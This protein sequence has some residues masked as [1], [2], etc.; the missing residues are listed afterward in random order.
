MA[1]DSRTPRLSNFSEYRLSSS[2]DAADTT[3]F[4]ASVDGLP[5][6]LSPLDY[7]PMVLRDAI[8]GREVIHVTAVDTVNKTVTALR[9]R[10]GTTAVNWGTSAYFYATMTSQA[11]LD[12]LVN[13]WRRPLLAD[14]TVAVP[15]RTA[16]DM[17]TIQE[18]Q[19]ALFVADCALRF[20]RGGAR[21]D[22]PFHVVSSSYS[23]G[24]G[25]TTVVVEDSTLDASPALDLVE[26]SQRPDES[27]RDV[28]YI[29]GGEPVQPLDATLTALAA[30]VTS[31]DKMIYA[32]G[33]DTFSLATITEFAR[34]ILDDVD[35]AAV[36]ATLGLV[37]GTNVQAQ[38]AN[39]AAL[40]GLTSAADKF[41]YFTGDGTAG[42]LTIVSAI[43]G[44]LAS[45]DVA[46]MRTNMGLG[47]AA[48]HDAADFAVPAK[49]S[50]AANLVL[51][52]TCGGA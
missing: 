49:L 21:V 52:A 10:E 45:A 33:A 30:L 15:T 51:Q 12:A 24:T 22:L 8:V 46:T 31:A 25:L 44:V 6:L 9:G 41:P 42:M 48:T 47:S 7:I 36:C 32:T 1:Y 18:D 19:T 4:L 14:G 17:F 43:R 16:A 11:I 27:P 13:T 35:A 29:S 28:R 39:L 3:L 37:I 5:E 34:S 2:A 26:V 38:S 40:A 23:A 20:F 50:V